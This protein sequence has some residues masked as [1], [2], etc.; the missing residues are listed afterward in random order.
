LGDVD[1]DG[2][3]DIALGTRYPGSVLAPDWI[4][5]NSGDGTF[6]TTTTACQGHP[7]LNLDFGDVDDDGDLDLAIV[8]HYSEYICI[9]GNVND[10]GDDKCSGTF[11]RTRWLAWRKDKNT[12]GLA[13]GDANRDDIL[14]VAVGR[15]SYANE[16]YLIDRDVNVSATLSFDPV[17]ERTWSVAWEDVD[18]DGDLDL[19]SGNSYRPTVIYFNEPVT[20]THSF[21]LTKPIVLG[22]GGHRTLSVAFGDVD[23]DGH[24]D[25]AVGSEGGQNVVYL[26]TLPNCV[27]L[28]IV[29]KGWQS[30]IGH[31]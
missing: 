19:A 30:A 11:T 24:P 31:N 15:E 22:T 2:D 23:G 21:T 29:M 20:T 4:Y 12:N 27:Y 7:T 14:D 28:P 25:L 3:L 8:G 6:V 16:V 26:N 17:W 18:H 5:Y 1:C 13:L 9:N 10:D